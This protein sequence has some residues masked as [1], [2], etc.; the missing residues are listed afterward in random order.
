MFKSINPE[1]KGLLD[2]FKNLVSKSVMEGLKLI[3]EKNPKRSNIPKYDQWYEI[4]KRDNGLPRPYISYN[5]SPE[6]YGKLFVSFPFKP[7]IPSENIVSFNDA[8]S[9][10]KENKVLS[11]YFSVEENTFV[12]V[13][14]FITSFIVDIIDRYIHIYNSKEYDSKKFEELY[15]P[16][17]KWYFE[18]EFDYD[19]AIPILFILFD[20]EEYTISKDIIIKKMSK[21]FQQSRASIG[22]YGSGVHEMV[23]R[24]ATHSFIFK[25]K[26]YKRDVGTPLLFYNEFED[27]SLYP[28]EYIS[29]LF[30]IM[31]IVLG[32]ET[33]FS[34]MIII[35][36][37]WARTYQ[38]NLPYLT[39]TSARYYPSWFDNFYWDT[40]DIPTY[41]VEDMDKVKVL[42]NQIQ[43]VNNKSME[44]AIRRINQCYLRH[45]ED[46]IIIDATIGLEAMLSDSGQSEMTH[47]LSMRVAAISQLS[48]Y[49]KMK[50][51]KVF[52]EMKKI[53]QARSM[54]VHGKPLTKN[55]RE[56]ESGGNKIAIHALALMYLKMTILLLS[57]YKEYLNPINIDTNLLLGDSLD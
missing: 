25:R 56:I 16:L 18:S 26:K 35:P 19:L 40:K 32:C 21:D 46:D 6:N 20:F 12:I 23:Q 30:G 52:E 14:V 7:I 27:I 53:Y 28:L 31:R 44:L 10:V 51:K 39:G 3:D 17:A 48:D 43:S 24:S 37:G 47:K 55:I 34:Q 22:N 57:E 38:Y 45:N 2:E 42:F 5:D 36:K 9:F 13:D 41:S 50:P 11:E 15:Y 54:I 1:M 49:I 4:D 8:I 33:G 29:K